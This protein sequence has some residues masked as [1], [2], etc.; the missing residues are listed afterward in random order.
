MIEKAT[1][2]SPLGSTCIHS[3]SSNN[4]PESQR[5][6]PEKQTETERQT[7]SRKLETETE[8]ERASRDSLPLQTLVCILKISAENSQ[9]NPSSWVSRKQTPSDAEKGFQTLCLDV[10]NFITEIKL[11]LVRE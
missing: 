10:I 7:E 9:K 6:R 11:L 3:H 8:T 1:Q 2:G 4:L 5:Q